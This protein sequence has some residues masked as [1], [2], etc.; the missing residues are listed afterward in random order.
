M[1]LVEI[2]CW[3]WLELRITNVS[4]ELVIGGHYPLGVSWDEFLVSCNAILA[5]W[6]QWQTKHVFESYSGNEWTQFMD[7]CNI[8]SWHMHTWQA[9]EC[10]KVVSRN[11]KDVFEFLYC[12]RICNDIQT[13]CDPD[14]YVVPNFVVYHVAVP[15][16]ESAQV[17]SPWVYAKTIGVT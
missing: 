11:W 12:L 2:C 17:C 1:V 3:A 4:S 8:H 6:I 7:V 10:G 15:V 14:W 13:D 9:K 16:V 5:F